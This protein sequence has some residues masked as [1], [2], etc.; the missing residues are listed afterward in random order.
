MSWNCQRCGEVLEA[1]FDACWKCGTSREGTADPT[2]ASRHAKAPRPDP[3]SALKQGFS[4]GK[5]G[6]TRAST[7]QLRMEK[8][9]VHLIGSVDFVAISCEGCGY[10]EFYRQ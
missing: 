5:C 10:S 7:E 1:T 6:G 2:F 4:C 9:G 8:R 3:A